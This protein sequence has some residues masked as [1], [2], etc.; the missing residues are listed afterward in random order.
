[1]LFCALVCVM[2]AG[3]ALVG[4]QE[5]AAPPPK[6]PAT[7]KVKAPTTQMATEPAP[8]VAPAGT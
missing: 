6:I 2:L 5:K 3:W 7:K 8:I 1:M 4:C